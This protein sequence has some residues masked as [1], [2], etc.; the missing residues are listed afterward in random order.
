[1]ALSTTLSAVRNAPAKFD[2][3]YDLYGS[4]KYSTAR[5]MLALPVH[6][7]HDVNLLAVCV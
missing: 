2:S 1:M 4:S 6:R 7:I 3:E 5:V